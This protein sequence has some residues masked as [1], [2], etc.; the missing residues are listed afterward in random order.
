MHLPAFVPRKS[1]CHSTRLGF[2]VDGGCDRWAG[3]GRDFRPIAAAKA[4]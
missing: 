3:G 1:L 2:R 4:K